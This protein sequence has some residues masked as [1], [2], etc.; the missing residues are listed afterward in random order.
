MGRHRGGSPVATRRAGTLRSW[1]RATT[2]EMPAPSR[3]LD[4][5][6]SLSFGTARR[7][8]ARRGLVGPRG[9][10]GACSPRRG[11]S[12]GRR[13]RSTAASSTESAN[14]RRGKAGM[15]C[16]SRGNRA[17]V[18]RP[19]RSSHTRNW[20]PH[21][22]RETPPMPPMSCRRRRAGRLG[23]EPGRPSLCDVHLGRDQITGPETGA[24]CGIP[25][26]DFPRILTIAST[27]TLRSASRT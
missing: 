8:E 25:A 20:T 13:A 22:S 9:S 16:R 2:L 17:G 15:R 11:V 1:L 21:A 27:H 18:A 26:I 23:L 3:A 19:R 12:A 6:Q 10:V 4:T 7:A 24:T 5:H 14:R